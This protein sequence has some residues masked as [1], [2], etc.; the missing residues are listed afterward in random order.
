MKTVHPLIFT[1]DRFSSLVL[2]LEAKTL[3][4]KCMAIYNLVSTLKFMFLIITYG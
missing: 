4:W 2:I 1:R 3:G